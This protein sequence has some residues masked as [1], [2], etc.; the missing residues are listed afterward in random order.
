MSPV[1]R[2][3]PNIVL[4]MTDDQGAW[5][6]GA[7]G[8]R[9]IITP[10]LDQLAAEGTRFDRFF[11]ASPVCSPARASLYTGLMPS[12]HGVHDW[13]SDRH[14]GPRG[15]NF[16]DGLEL[17]TDVL[18]KH[19]YRCGLAGKWHLGAN[20]VPRPG[21]V[22]WFSHQSGGGVYTNAPV[23]RDGAL[24][25][26]PGYVT[27]AFTADACAF[28]RREA[29]RDRNAPFFLA[30]NYTAPHSPW[31]DQHPRRLTELYDD[32]RFETAPQAPQHPW[33]RVTALGTP[34]EGES[35]LRAAL[36]GYYASITGVDE[37]VGRVLAELDRLGIR[38]D[39]LVVFTSDNGF[40]CG[41]HGFWGKG[42]GTNPQNLYESSI[43]VPFIVNQP[44]RV[45]AGRT[46][47]AL[48][49]AYDVKATLLEYA[50][51][52]HPGDPRSPGRSFVDLIEGSDSGAERERV[53]VADEYGG[54]RMIR[55]EQWKYVRRFPLGP[56]E[57]YDLAA[58]PWERHNLVGDPSQA[59]R[60]TQLAEELALWFAKHTDPLHDARAASVTGWGQ[61][62]Y[63]HVPGAFNQGPTDRVT[64]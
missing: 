25:E 45:P 44:G 30:L 41:Q 46:V 51:I 21:F 17:V 54:T 6:L 16:L 35:D 15:Q 10:H 27:D 14:V 55:T 58:D 3:H 57:L 62:E 1:S 42:N 2:Q 64:P 26:Q 20:D 18:A 40:S 22:H 8:N 31:K 53:V 48:V 63:D 59:R 36:V 13:I 33:A 34:A 28:I 12:A 39:T 19:G 47:R 61:V 24:V 43:L 37:G 11:C 32:C 9:E 5:A 4:V 56:D 23:V 50:G 60:V 38:D 52:D 7:S 29:G 49:S